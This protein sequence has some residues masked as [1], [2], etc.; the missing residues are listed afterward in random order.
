MVDACL[1]IAE[2][3]DPKELTV[4]ED[5]LWVAAE[6][7]VNAREAPPKRAPARREMTVADLVGRVKI[8]MTLLSYTK[9]DPVV[10]LVTLC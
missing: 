6:Y 2:R 8:P 5:P 1:K 9:Y 7:M 3:I 4:G 10:R